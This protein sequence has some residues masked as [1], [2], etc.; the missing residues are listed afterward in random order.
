MAM[1]LLL[2]AVATC[3]SQGLS[4][5]LCRC[6]GHVF[7]GA[8][9]ESCC[10]ECPEEESATAATAITTTAGHDRCLLS[11]EDCF[12]RVSKGWETYPPTNGKEEAPAPAAAAAEPLAALL[13]QVPQPVLTGMSSWNLIHQPEPPGLSRVLLYR[14]LLI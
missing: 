7:V 11:T 4:A 8:T 10:G 5:A 3:A 2:V 12:I 9:P 13:S 1:I 6:T 14:S